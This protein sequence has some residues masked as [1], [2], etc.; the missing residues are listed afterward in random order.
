MPPLSRDRVGLVLAIEPFPIQ[1]VVPAGAVR[2]RAL[3]A[4]V[5]AG[6]GRLAFRAGA[7]FRDG[8]TGTPYDDRAGPRGLGSGST[9]SRRAGRRDDDVA[10]L[11]VGGKGRGRR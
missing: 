4:L 11:A 10:L 3:K 8:R 5:A 9:I 6:G 1:V 7:G 2:Q